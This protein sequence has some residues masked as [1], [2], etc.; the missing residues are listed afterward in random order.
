MPKLLTR[1]SR[2][3]YRDVKV[4]HP[5]EVERSPAKVSTL[6]C[7]ILSR[8][9]SAAFVTRASDRPFTITVAFSR[10]NPSAIAKPIPA[11]DPVTKAS[12]PLIS[13]S[14]KIDGKSRYDNHACLDRDS[15]SALVH[16]QRSH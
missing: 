2:L 6:A 14:I 1:I 4:S 9:R 12:F 13:R 3:G 8:I 10:A 16:S 7:G 5:S 15:A 11:D